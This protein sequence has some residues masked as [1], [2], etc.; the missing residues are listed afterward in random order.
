[1]LSALT[2]TVDLPPEHWS[3]PC[4]L[5]QKAVRSRLFVSSWVAHR[6]CVPLNGRFLCR[7]QGGLFDEQRISHGR[8]VAVHKGIDCHPLF[9]SS[10]NLLA[11]AYLLVAAARARQL[12]TRDCS[13]Q[14]FQLPE[15]RPIGS[16][17]LRVTDHVMTLLIP[18]QVQREST[19]VDRW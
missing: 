9:K 5:A 2:Y 11:I 12:A 19:S 10:S 13:A 4:P 1:M 8:V 6:V 18:S 7:V 16:L 15:Q 3:C 14:S 17:D